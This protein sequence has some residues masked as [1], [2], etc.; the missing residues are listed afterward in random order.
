MEEPTTA[1]RLAEIIASLKEALLHQSFEA[2]KLLRE[3]EHE[4]NYGEWG[5]FENF[6]ES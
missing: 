4:K 3:L 6:V 5:T 1:S 2:G